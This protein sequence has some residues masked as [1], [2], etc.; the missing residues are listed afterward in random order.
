M[1]DTLIEAKIIAIPKE[2]PIEIFDIHQTY[3]ELQ[4]EV[5]SGEQVG[6]IYTLENGTVPMVN[7]R[8]YQVG[9]KVMV[10]FSDQRDP[11]TYYIADY[12]RREAMGILAL[13]FL[14]VILSVAKKQGLMAILGMI[15]TFF[16]IFKVTLPLILGGHSPFWVSILTVA[17]VIPVTFYLSH[18]F[19]RKT[20]AAVIATILTL[21]ITVL[22][23]FLA[24]KGIHL[25]GYASEDSSFI[26]AII[27]ESIDIRGLLLAGIV[28]ATL[29]VINDVTVAQASVVNEIKTSE[30]KIKFS[31]LYR[32]SMIV[33]RDHIASM[34][35][36]LVLTYA[37]ASLPLL[38]LLTHSGLPW[39][40][41]IN[42][43]LIAEEI[44]RTLVGSIGLILA[45]PITTVIAASMIE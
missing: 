10:G 11:Q 25:T 40:Q 17:I 45:V 28:I 22:L 41:T 5:T 2:E 38:V 4:L 30:P 27:G 3:Q 15:F 33:G 7:Q 26:T 37:G 31:D 19:K 29:G 8:L 1:S 35:D 14:F 23:G 12:I 18:G 42:M 20:H 24:V 34:V 9:D 43:E 32:R 44:A 13:L 21:I 6:S 39:A 16:I 36:T